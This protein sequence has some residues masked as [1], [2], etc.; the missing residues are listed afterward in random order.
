MNKTLLTIVA[1][2]LSPMASAY[3]FGH[4]VPLDQT[5]SATFYI[6]GDIEGAGISSM[7]VDTGATYTAIDQKM[8]QKLQRGGHATYVKN[9]MGVMADGSR[10]RVDVYR[11]SSINL[12]GD[13]VVRDVEAAVFPQQV[14]PILGLSALTKVSPFIFSTNPPSLSLSNCGNY[15]IG[16]ADAVEQGPAK[17]GKGSLKD[18]ENGDL[19]AMITAN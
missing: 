11:I 18:V 14:R 7:L 16:S 6:E 2:L 17:W 3:D 13:C 1:A 4:E 10:L 15:T 19:S 9:L 8:L 12:G 5:S